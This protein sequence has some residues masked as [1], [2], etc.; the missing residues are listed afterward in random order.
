M[1]RN[2]LGR[3][4]SG[5][6]EHPALQAWRKVCSDRVEPDFV[7]VLREGTKSCIYRLSSAGPGGTTVIAKR[8]RAAETEIEQTIYEQIL[9][10]LPISHL[11]YYGRFDE[12]DT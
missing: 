2:I 12:T 11:A 8:C 4:G 3:L 6:A 10:S 1:P 9:P 5:A 7:E